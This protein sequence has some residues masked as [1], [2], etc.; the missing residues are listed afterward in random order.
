MKSTKLTK[1]YLLFKKKIENCDFP[2]E[3]LFE[4]WLLQNTYIPSL[5][6]FSISVSPLLFPSI[7]PCCLTE[8]NIF[9]SFLW[10]DAFVEDWWQY[11]K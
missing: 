7:L 2:R 3:M 8:H 9:I 5:I 4:S 1:G 10:L 6:S 11:E